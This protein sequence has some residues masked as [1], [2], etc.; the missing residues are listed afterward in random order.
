MSYLL[1]IS[2]QKKTCIFCFWILKL[3]NSL[4]ISKEL[5]KSQEY[6]T[7]DSKTLWSI[8]LILISV[9]YQNFY[10]QYIN[11]INLWGRS[12]TSV[13]TKN[14]KILHMMYFIQVTV[15]NI[16]QYCL[17]IANNAICT[18]WCICHM[19]S[20]RLCI[21]SGERYFLTLLKEKDTATCIA[22]YLENKI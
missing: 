11:Y 6:I 19:I 5:S 3:L 16:V 17:R 21:I 20:N 22:E 10:L 15:Y 13:Y 9:F 7:S 12:V 18:F 4:Q 1:L 8:K 2:P 14:W